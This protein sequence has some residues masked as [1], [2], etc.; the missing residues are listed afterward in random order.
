MKMKGPG[1][2]NFSEE[3]IAM[4]TDKFTSTRTEREERL[5]QFELGLEKEKTERNL[6]LQYFIS[7]SILR[8]VQKKLI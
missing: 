4:H 8:V 1:I 5:P 3:I 2:C 6:S 7:G